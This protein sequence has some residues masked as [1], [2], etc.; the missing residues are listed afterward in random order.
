MKTKHK[1][2]YHKQTNSAA[3]QIFGTTCRNAQGLRAKVAHT[4]LQKDGGE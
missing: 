1:T 2:I 4:I 3:I